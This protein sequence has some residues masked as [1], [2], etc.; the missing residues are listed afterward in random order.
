MF[1][2]VV[3]S[4]ITCTSKNSVIGIDG[5][6]PWYYPKDLIFF[7]NVTSGY[8]VIMGRK[9]FESLG[10]ALSGRLNIVISSS[11]ISDSNVTRATSLENALEICYYNKANR[12]FLIGGESV[13]K[14]G[15]KYA[16]EILLTR[17]LRNVKGDRK[18]PRIPMNF[19]IDSYDFDKAG[20]FDAVFLRY[21]K[22][23]LSL[24]SFLKNRFKYKVL[25]FINKIDWWISQ[26]STIFKRNLKIIL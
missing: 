24:F 12:V 6:I 22:S 17:I 26:K 13:Y 23:D 14:A 20:A 15:L 1:N 7:K 4:I 5:K 19:K 25:N 8:P 16:D 3:V 9:T 21:L 11:E 10:K 2:N 18:F